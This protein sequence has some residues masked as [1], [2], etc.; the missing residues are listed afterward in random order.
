M[1]TIDLDAE[2][3]EIVRKLAAET[4]IAMHE[5]LRRAAKS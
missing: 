5:V 3:R 4:G 2:T 1:P